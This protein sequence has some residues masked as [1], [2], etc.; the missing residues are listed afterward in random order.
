MTTRSGSLEHLDELEAGGITEV[1]YRAA[2]PDVPREFEAF[3]RGVTDR[4]A[5]A[6]CT[7]FTG[8]RPLRQAPA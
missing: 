5:P 4:L 6:P 2:G 3:A 7:D 8:S 1:A